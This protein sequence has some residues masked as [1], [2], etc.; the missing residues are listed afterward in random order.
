MC[1]EFK[2]AKPCDIWARMV[3]KVEPCTELFHFLPAWWFDGILAQSLEWLK[4]TDIV[5]QRNGDLTD[6]M[7]YYH[8]N[9]QSNLSSFS[10]LYL[11]DRGTTH[12]LICLT[13][14]TKCHFLVSS[15]VYFSGNLLEWIN[16][17]AKNENSFCNFLTAS[18]SIPGQTKR[19]II[20]TNSSK[21][22]ST[23]T[24]HQILLMPSCNRTK[25]NIYNVIISATLA[26]R[27]ENIF[28]S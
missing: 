7:T 2:E 28:A 16:F 8:I 18:L 17:T 24:A 20:L 12:E 19:T 21:N 1:R 3:I 27:L 25:K 4:S 6:Q 26:A 9:T 15:S 5:N 10:L 11:R 13:W 22:N 23:I 14:I